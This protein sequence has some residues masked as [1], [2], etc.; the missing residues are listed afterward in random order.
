MLESTKFPEDRRVNPKA[1]PEYVPGSPAW[2]SNRAEPHTQSPVQEVG[3]PQV[4]FERMINAAL[5]IVDESGPKALSMRQLAERIESGTATLYRHFA[6]KDEILAYVV[7]LVLGEVDIDTSRLS[8]PSWQQ[9]CAMGA[10]ALYSV[11]YA[12]PN[13]VPLIGAQIPVGPNALANREKVLAALLAHGFP[14]NFAARAYSTIMHYVLGFSSQVHATAGLS[15]TETGQLRDYYRTL[16]KAGFPATVAV[17]NFLPRIS[18]D[19]EFHFGLKL[20]IAGL[21]QYHE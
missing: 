9:A 5:K 14:P 12:H 8:S 10:E 19:E 11:L 2:W 18:D 16:N 4:P 21:E 20:I 13:V 7:D 15:R 17:A 1:Q 3:R 6:S